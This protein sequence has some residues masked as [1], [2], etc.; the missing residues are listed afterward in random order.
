MNLIHRILVR[1][2]TGSPDKRGNT[3]GRPAPGVEAWDP[4]LPL[5]NKEA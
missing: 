2:L 4:P 1:H 3:W 5:R